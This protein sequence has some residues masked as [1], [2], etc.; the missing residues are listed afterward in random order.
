MTSPLAP[1]SDK[2][3]PDYVALG[4]TPTTWT[5]IAVLPRKDATAYVVRLAEAGV[6][7]LL[8]RDS[9]DPKRWH[10]AIQGGLAASPTAWLC[11]IRPDDHPR[12]C[13]GSPGAQHPIAV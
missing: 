5:C 2:P 6:P 9:A 12:V 3:S 13:T 10:V 1:H 7:A 11:G 8:A 4:I